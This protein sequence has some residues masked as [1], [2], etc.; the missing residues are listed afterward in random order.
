MIDLQTSTKTFVAEGYVSHNSTYV[1]GRF[2]YE[3]NSK[4]N[5]YAC[6]AS[7]DIDASNKV[8]KM[9]K[10]FQNLM[11]A[12]LKRPTE[13][14]NRKEIIYSAPHRSEFLVQTAGKQVLGRGGLTHYL[15]P[16]EFAF[17]DKAKEQFGGAA[18]EVPDKPDSII[19]IESTAFG[20][21]G[22]FY[23]M[24]WQAVGDWK[25]TKDLN[26]YLPIFLPWF[27]FPDYQMMI[28]THIQFEIGKSHGVIPDEWVAYEPELVAKYNLCPEQL[29][30]R[31]WAIKN[32]CQS[33]LVIFLQE[34]PATA[35]EAFQT[36][37]RAVFSQ[38]LLER[39]SL[40]TKRGVFGLFER[41]N[42]GKVS[43]RRID[44]E[45]E[46]WHMLYPPL[47]GHEYTHGTDVMEGRPSDPQNVKSKVDYHGSAVL[48][49]NNGTYVCIYHGRCDPVELGSQ[50]VMCSEFYN[51]AWASPEVNDAGMV[52]LACYKEAGYPNIY[53]RQRYDQNLITEEAP[54][55]GWRTDV[56]TRKWLIDEFKASVQDQQMARGGRLTIEFSEI[57][58]EMRTFHI[59][60]MGKATHLPGEHDDLLFA[61]MIAL[62]LHIRCPIHP[63][64][65]EFDKTGAAEADEPIKSLARVG[66]FD[67]WEP[68]D[69]EDDTEHTV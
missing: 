2:F 24:F 45:S 40:K 19:V 41:D 51:T 38:S 55:L 44:R 25:K 31:R 47:P 46:C 60:K 56:L 32:K 8:F 61:A 26:N 63:M 57:I 36:T 48:D 15:H 4:S 67:D 64:P 35:R 29:Y 5:R 28:P 3:I 42:N 14:S 34:Y 7:M 12:E 52:V 9:S 59:D 22:T 33:D 21:G 68:T 1:E 65:Y 54:Q 10:L 39:L 62:Q 17:W 6:I 37:G 49:R 13:Y 27:I 69:E 50:C 23:D 18:Q 58:Q 11:P 20:V 53:Q 16:T 66:T 30:W 43:F